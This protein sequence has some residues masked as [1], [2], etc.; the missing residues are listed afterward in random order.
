[1]AISFLNSIDLNQNQ[2]IQA[3]IENQPNNTAAGTGVEGQLYYD[4]TVDLLKV[5]TGSAWT[6]VGAYTGW[7]LAGNTGTS[8]VINTGNTASI[9]GAGVI[10][11]AASATDTLTITHSNVTRTNTTDT[12]TLT[13]GSTFTAIT[14]LTSDSQGHVTAGNTKTYTLPGDKYPSAFTWTGGTTAGPTGSLTGTDSMPAVAY[15]AIPS[16]TGS[17]SGVVTTTTQ[18]F[19]GNKTFSGNTTMSGTLSVTST[20]QSSFAGQV[21]IP[22]TPVANTDAASKN[23][24]D[25]S[26]IGQSVFQGGYNAATNTPDL[27]VAPSALIKKGWF[28]AVTVEGT[29]FSEVVQ[30]GDLIYAN[31]DNPGNTF[32]NWT[33]VQSGS[34]VVSVSASSAN[35]RLGLGIS[36]TTGAV[37]AGL[38]IDTLATDTF[39]DSADALPIYDVSTATN[40]KITISDL[41]TKINAVNSFTNLG[42]ATS[43]TT[44]T[45]DAATHGLGSDSSNIMVQL[46]QASTGD[47]IYS[48]VTRGPAGLITI[49][50]A[51]AQAANSVRALLQKI[52]TT[53]TTPVYFNSWYQ[54]SG[55]VSNNSTSG[56]VTIAAG[57]TATFNAYA[58][59][60]TGDMAV[61]TSITINGVTRTANAT[62]ATGRVE[63]TTF[64][65]SPGIYNYSVT[66]NRTGTG[67]TVG[68]G[69]IEYTQP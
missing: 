47:T 31:V 56:T 41:A 1:M 2:L 24:V 28:W 43:S 34:E 67:G 38:A 69:G 4:T 12:G 27:D 21:T 52:L 42:P 51:V 19:G 49:T 3:R 16:A 61:S 45:I 39:Y 6:E 55:G 33:V 13:P 32:S 37:V 29:F 54:S 46:V 65:L 66:V 68:G 62:F 8:Q 53:I 36:P 64:Q 60:F 26:N 18:T 20:A 30:P 25:Q 48:D 35:N 57:S 22:L 59:V 17:A 11:T 63:S 50:F 40:K 58:E 14:T 5:W 23:Y 44:Y 9:V 15:A 7:T 10:T